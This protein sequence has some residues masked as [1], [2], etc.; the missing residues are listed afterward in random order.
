MINATFGIQ[1]IP[2]DNIDF[3]KK[4][5]Y[6]N[7]LIEFIKKIPNININVG[8]LET[9]IEGEK[10]VVID[11]MKNIFDYIS[12]YDVK[13]FIGIKTIIDS[14]NRIMTIDEK[15]KNK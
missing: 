4:I 10:T 15:I 1:L 13:I 6:I 9:T 3:D 7:R 8:P 12:K 5:N 2:L 11:A 14:N